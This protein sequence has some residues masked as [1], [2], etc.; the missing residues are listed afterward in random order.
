MK[1]DLFK[2]IKK[3]HKEVKDILNKLEKTSQNV[4]RDTLFNELKQEIKPH[5]KAEEHVFYPALE[6]D[7][8]SRK[9]ALESIEEHHVTELV[10]NEL[11]AMSKSEDQWS[12]KLSVFKELVDHH[13]QEEESKIFKDA[14]EV[15]SDN[16]FDQIAQ[17]FKQ[18]KES[19]KGAM[20]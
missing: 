2:E 18:E 5:M 6:K 7:K 11:D 20:A 17:Q 16:Q 1:D 4:Q 19:I 14:R 12:A 10:L 9:D 15:L 13:I 3:D 8:K